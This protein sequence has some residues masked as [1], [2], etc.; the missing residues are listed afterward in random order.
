MVVIKKLK[1]L[2]HAMMWTWLRVPKGPC[3]GGLVLDDGVGRWLTFMRWGLVGGADLEGM[4]A[5][6]EGCYQSVI[7]R[8]LLI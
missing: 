8:L 5:P 6:Q 4:E 7:I 2:V 1:M 3:V